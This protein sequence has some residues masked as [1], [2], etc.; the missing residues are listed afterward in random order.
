MT[1]IDVLPIPS[2]RRTHFE[3]LLAYLQMRDQEEW[4]YGNRKQ[5]EKRHDELK[6]WLEE[7]VACMEELK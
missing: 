1:K 2:F 7:V 4:Y 3:Q 6:S 5:F